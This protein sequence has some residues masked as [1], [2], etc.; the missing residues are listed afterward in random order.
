MID[1]AT[2]NGARDSINGDFQGIV[3]VDSTGTEVSD[4][5]PTS[6]TPD[7][8]PT[9]T[10]DTTTDGRIQLAQ[11]VP[12]SI[13]A[14]VEVAGW[15]AKS[16]STDISGKWSSWDNGFILGE[17]FNKSVTFSSAGVFTLEGTSTYIQISLV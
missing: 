15:R 3:L 12:F 4:V 13:N 11:D 9:Y 6:S 14:G 5:I 1:T 7:F 16:G 10:W 8:T 2:L 17:D